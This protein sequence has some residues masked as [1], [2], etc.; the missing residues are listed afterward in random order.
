MTS[1]HLRAPRAR[2][3]GAVL[4]AALMILIVLTLLVLAA[5]RGSTLLERLTGNARQLDQA[6]QTAEAALREGE[7]R[8]A[9]AALPDAIQTPGWYHHSAKPAPDWSQPGA[10]DA[11]TNGK[12]AYAVGDAT[13]QV[14]IEELAPVPDPGG[15]LNPTEQPQDTT[16]YR[17]SAR[18]YG[19]RGDTFVILQTTY[20]R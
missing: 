19:E 1:T 2:Q 11:A 10:W 13:A 8:L 9:A 6:F 16:V 15:G 14:A 4:M 5:T 12:I 7:R 18:G 17:I 3:S 20:R